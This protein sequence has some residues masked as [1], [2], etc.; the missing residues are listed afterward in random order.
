MLKLK[1]GLVFFLL[2]VVLSL[3]LSYAGRM[4]GTVVDAESGKPIEGAIVLVEWTM[5]KGIGLTHTTSYSAKEKVTDRDGRFS[6]NAVLNP[7][8]NAPDV[9]IYKKGYVAWNSR[10]IFPDRR[11]RTDFIWGDNIFKLEH[12]KEGYSYDEHTDFIRLSINSSM[13]LES[14]K[15]IYD[16]FR[17]EDQLAFEERQRLGTIIK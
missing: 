2:F 13:N 6:V 10:W 15:L 7:F 3:I 9:T 14:K 5:K 17:W 12:F 4:T 16:A 8:V 1:I 11:N